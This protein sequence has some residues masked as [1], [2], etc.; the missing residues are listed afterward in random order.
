M[1]YE[2][3]RFLLFNGLAWRFGSIGWVD[4]NR[5]GLRGT[6]HHSPACVSYQVSSCITM[7]KECTI[8]TLYI[9]RIKKHYQYLE[10]DSFLKC[11]HL[12]HLTFNSLVNSKNDE[13]RDISQDDTNLPT[14]F[15]NL[16]PSPPF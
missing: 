16:P 15:Q 10:Q 14:T 2:S 7:G 11:V 5:E 12:R 3:E 6:V 9:T 13:P 1:N 8:D 4:T